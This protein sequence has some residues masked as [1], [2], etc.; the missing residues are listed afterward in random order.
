[1]N[2][3]RMLPLAAAIAILSSIGGFAGTF[4]VIANPSVRADSITPAQLRSVFMEESRSLGDGSHVEPVV[5]R[6]GDAHEEF[7]KQYLGKDSEE[8]QTY[9]RSLVFT[10][11]GSMPKTLDSDAEIADY[12]AKNKGAIGYVSDQE[13]ANG[14]KILTI[15]DTS[16]LSQRK[17]L[18][19]IEP[20]YPD[21][22]KR[23][24]IGGSVRLQVTISAKGSVET[25]QVLGGNPILGEAAQA[26]VKQ[27]IYAP[28]HAPSTAEVVIPFD[29]SKE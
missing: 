2:R 18:I 9:Y 7:L 6:R 15:V 27:W 13:P 10:G 4:K 12:V 25:V 3:R 5:A 29:P 19:R 20:E 24:K 26:A 11:K 23:M 14:V 21:T 28:S 17:L 8:L 16:K 22:L 1:M